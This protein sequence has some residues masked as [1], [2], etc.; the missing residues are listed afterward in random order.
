MGCLGQVQVTLISKLKRTVP[1]TNLE[2]LL[3]NVMTMVILNSGV[4]WEL[5]WRVKIH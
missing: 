5:N 3:I 2:C 4:W 1:N